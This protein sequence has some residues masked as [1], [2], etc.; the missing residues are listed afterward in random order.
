MQGRK[1]AD[2]NNLRPPI[3]TAPGELPDIAD[4]VIIGGGIV[5]V[6]TA[7]ELARSGAK[8]VLCEKGRIG[9]EAS[10]RAV[11]WIDNQLFSPAKIEI[12]VAAKRLWAK[13]AQELGPDLGYRQ[14]GLLTIL[15]DAAARAQAQAWLDQ[16]ACFQGV[17]AA[18]Y[19]GSCLSALAPWAKPDDV[20]LFQPSDASVE[21][22]TAAPV[23]AEA[24]RKAGAVIL[25]NCAV[26]GLEHDAGRVNGV[27]T[28][29]GRVKCSKVVLAAGVWAPLF[30]KS[31]GL[32]LPQL[33][34]FASVLRTAPVANGPVY[35][36]SIPGVIWR[37][38]A[39]GGYSVARLHGLAPIT[40]DA[41]RHMRAFWPAFR[42]MRKEVTP[43][44]GRD[45]FHELRH[46]SRWPLTQPS[47]FETCRVFSPTPRPAPLHKA[48][49][50]LARAIPAFA[51]AR[52]EDIWAGALMNTP[53]NMP[54]ISSV[55]GLEGVF[56][57]AGFYYG[58]TMAPAAGQALAA[59]AMGETPQIDLTAFRFSRFSDGSRLAL[60][61]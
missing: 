31:L 56:L 44:L 42:A 36:G 58:L 43:V 8:V 34:I 37:K 53:D 46:P 12:T 47:L 49:A 57:G 14:C 19:A 33:K 18:L 2:M 59:L 26:R 41:L 16:T 55:P 3:V 39:D 23:I 22:Q 15:P 50:E 7:L 4:V 30:C 25:Q 6:C 40:P 17:D 61:A 60:Q 9:G 29:H 5:G 52:V 10:G 1:R 32:T 24:A 35:S 45:F 48:L 20:G 21:P 51:G 13:L 54:V 27:V 38:R 11:G 28:E